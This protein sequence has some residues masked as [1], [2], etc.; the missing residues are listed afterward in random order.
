MSMTPLV[1]DGTPL[2]RYE[3]PGGSVWV[4]RED[5]CC[6]GGPPFSK[7]RGVV[8][9]LEGRAE[10]SIGVLDTLHSMAGWRVAYACRALGKR[11]TVFFPRYKDE[12]G[13]RAN[14]R[15]C[16]D[17]GARL[18]PLPA[19]RSAILFH[20]ARK[21]LALSRGSYMIPNAL[22]IPEAV[23]AHARE[24]ENFQQDVGQEAV[25]VVSVSSGTAASGVLRGLVRGGFNV[26][27][28]VLHLGYSRSEAAVLRYVRTTAGIALPP[29][30]N[31]DVVDEGYAYRDAV[32]NSAPFPSNEHY[33]AKAWRWLERHREKL[34]T[35]V[36][37]W[38]I[39]A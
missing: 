15:R 9:H 22:K 20:R 6:P 23:E 14:Q 17:L 21:I 36:V 18:V 7:M 35:R 30:V 13:L 2:E 25:F 10:R 33:D 24:A 29:G 37:F 34:G 12:T 19:G 28:L 8:P 11:A 26:I 31:L 1:S 39:G 4:K 5:L 27:R 38:N 32:E 16:L 3:L